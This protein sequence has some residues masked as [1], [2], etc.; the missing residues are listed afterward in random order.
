MFAIVYKF[1]LVL[2]CIQL[3]GLAALPEGAGDI[4]FHKDQKRDHVF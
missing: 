4:L 2:M 1:N 3:T